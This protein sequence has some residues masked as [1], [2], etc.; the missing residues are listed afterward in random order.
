MPRHIAI[1][2]V[3]LAALAACEPANNIGAACYPGEPTDT[4]RITV[5]SP[6]IECDSRTC[7]A[8][9]TTSESGTGAPA[10]PATCTDLCES[11]ADCAGAD[12]R[13]CPGGFTCAVPVVTGA[14]CC[15]TMCV[16]RDD[17]AALPQP[18]PTPPACDPDDP[19]NTCCNLPGRD[20]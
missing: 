13:H 2:I 18:Q 17:L 14:F 1:P 11:D 12:D 5:T 10:A 9:G 6:S 7:L 20:C 16:C 3:L 8:V 4:A 19:T 15:K